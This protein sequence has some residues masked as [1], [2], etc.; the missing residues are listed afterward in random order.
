LA[1]IAMHTKEISI[2]QTCSNHHQVQKALSRSLDDFAR[3][4]TN[5]PTV[6]NLQRM[7]AWTECAEVDR[8][9]HRFRDEISKC[10]FSVVDEW[11]HDWA[12][13]TDR[14]EQARHYSYHDF[15][16]C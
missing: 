9:E 2:S 7:V 5:Q 13:N 15:K 10:P 8:Q 14:A 11:N 3:I 6:H 12:F 16:I 1:R 4:E